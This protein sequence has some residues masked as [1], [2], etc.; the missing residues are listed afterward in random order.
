MGSVREN[1]SGNEH[2]YGGGV[3]V[4]RDLHVFQREKRLARARKKV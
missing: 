4:Y 1:F 2:G 3:H